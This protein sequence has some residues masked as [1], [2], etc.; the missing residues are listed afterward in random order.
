MGQWREDKKQFFEGEKILC[1]PCV[2]VSAPGLSHMLL[3][4]GFY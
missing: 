3:H 2:T 4:L 1:G